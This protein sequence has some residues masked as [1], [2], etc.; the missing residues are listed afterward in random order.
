MAKD[1]KS[2]DKARNAS[3]TWID[4]LGH[5]TASFETAA[6]GGPGHKV[7][8]A[9]DPYVI[10]RQ[11]YYRLNKQIDEENNHVQD[12]LEIQGAFQQFEAYILKNIQ[13]AMGSFVQTVA[14]QAEQT[15]VHYEDMSSTAQRIPPDFEW[16]RFY[17]RQS[18]VLLDPEAPTKSIKHVKFPNQNHPSTQPLI[19]GELQRKSRLLGKG[20]STGYYVVTPSKY[21]HEFNDDDDFSSEPIPELSLYLPDCTIGSV[22]GSHFTVKGKNVSKGKLGSALATKHELEFK[23]HS[24][25]EAERWWKIIR[26]IAIGDSSIPESSPVDTELSTP[27]VQQEQKGLSEGHHPPAYAEEA[28]KQQ[29]Y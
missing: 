1:L 4:L 15:K 6:I 23:A 8:P 9:T 14:A 24:T 3:Q 7:D 2:V 13:Q 18:H 25:E 12:L 5:H 28:P 22:E 27:V 17:Q 29:Q 19:A 21:L 20:Y 26:E 10:Q 11:L 16:S